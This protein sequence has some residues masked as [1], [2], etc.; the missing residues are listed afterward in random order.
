MA[1]QLTDEQIAECKEAFALFDKDGDGIVTIQEL[2]T[3]MRSLGQNPTEAE[4][5]DI[6]IQVDGTGTLDGT[7]DLSEFL[8]LMARRIKDTE[9]GEE[10]RDAFKVFDTDGNGFIS[11]AELRHVMASQGDPVTD[12]EVEDM[13][14]QADTDGDGQVNYAEFVKMV[15]AK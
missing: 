11:P 2:G 9:P 1:E 3:V 4:L 10:L 6:I 12:E 7:L 15:M 5:Q 13:I 14:R 8:D